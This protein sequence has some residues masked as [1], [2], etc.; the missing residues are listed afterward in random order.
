MNL[1]RTVSAAWPPVLLYLLLAGGTLLS[2][3]GFPAAQHDQNMFHA[4]V[5]RKF[6]AEWPVMDVANYSTATG[7]TY[8]YLL[9]TGGKVVGTD[10]GTLRLLSMPIGILLL[11]AVAGWCAA[12]VPARAAAFLTLP[13]ATS[14]T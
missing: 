8:H 11:V 13:L 10:I 2:G 7:P 9:A 5:V 6:A 14:I 12:V 3:R 4:Q 1:R